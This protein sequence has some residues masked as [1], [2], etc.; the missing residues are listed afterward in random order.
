MRTLLL[1]KINANMIFR[2]RDARVASFCWE[3]WF[4]LAIKDGIVNTNLEYDNGKLFWYRFKQ[5]CNKA[6]DLVFISYAIL[7][8]KV[9]LLV[10]NE[11]LLL[12]CNQ[13]YNEL[14]PYLHG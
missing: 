11:L 4:A 6:I 7:P 14:I 13:F 10:L 8:H 12:H 3:F 2:R 5:F 9:C 1:F